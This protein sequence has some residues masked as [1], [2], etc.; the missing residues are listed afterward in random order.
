MQLNKMLFFARDATSMFHQRRAFENS[1]IFIARRAFFK[2]FANF[3]DVIS[4]L[5]IITL[6]QFAIC[7]KILAHSMRVILQKKILI[8]QFVY[9]VVFIFMIKKTCFFFDDR[10]F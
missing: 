1:M 2:I 6:F 5:T 7:V 9:F 10:L 4:F 3:V 8:K